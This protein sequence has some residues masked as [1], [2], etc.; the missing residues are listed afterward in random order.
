VFTSRALMVAVVSAVFE[1][2]ATVMKSVL[3]EYRSV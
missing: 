3:V 1:L 2:P